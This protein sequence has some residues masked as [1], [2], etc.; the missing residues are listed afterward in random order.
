M[1]C[2]FCSQSGHNATNCNERINARARCIFENDYDPIFDE[3]DKLN[4]KYWWKRIMVKQRL[5]SVT[6]YYIPR[7]KTIDVDSCHMGDKIDNLFGVT[8]ELNDLMSNNTLM[9]D[10]I[11]V[12][13]RHADENIAVVIGCNDV[14]WRTF[15]KSWFSRGHHT[16]LNK[17]FTSRKDSIST[18]IRVLDRLKV[19][20]DEHF[21]NLL[22]L[23]NI[24]DTDDDSILDSDDEVFTQPQTP[25]QMP[26]APLFPT[27][28]R[29][30]T[31]ILPRIDL[32]NA[33]PPPPDTQPTN[34]T[35]SDSTTCGICWDELG[36]ANVMVTKCGHKF[37][38]DCILSH[39]QNAAGTNCPLCR[40]EYATRVSGWLPPQ[41]EDERPRRRRG[42][43]RRQYQFERE[44]TPELP[45]VPDIVPDIVPE[46]MYVESIDRPHGNIEPTN[47]LNNFI[48]NTNSQ[49]NNTNNQAQILGYA[50]LNAIQS[51]NN[52]N[53]R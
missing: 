28:E 18:R 17:C 32:E 35:V 10:D 41:E 21:D 4:R 11:N 20:H 51:I 1:P 12:L 50:I 44:M 29:R 6:S 27:P 45:L 15:P 39:F 26:P 23:D 31:R 14:I 48:N 38:C 22:Y 47:L 3:D 25:E 52:S 16:N 34:V 5:G 43:P 40:E 2:S 19:L 36:E 46:N 9:Y 8:D 24:L 30:Q 53:S 42:R 49:D 33:P 7:V 37:C 13:Y